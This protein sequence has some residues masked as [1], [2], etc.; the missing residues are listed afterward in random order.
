MINREN[1]LIKTKNTFYINHVSLKKVD[2]ENLG[3]IFYSN[4]VWV[5]KVDIE[6]LGNIF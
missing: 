4:R 2:I 5:K 1:K 6:N 3:N